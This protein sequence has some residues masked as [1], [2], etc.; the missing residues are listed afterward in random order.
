MLFLRLQKGL[1]FNFIIP[2]L[3]FHYNIIKLTIMQIIVDIILF[4]LVLGI[5]G[6]QWDTWQFWLLLVLLIIIATVNA[7][8]GYKSID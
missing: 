2:L 3:T 6:L 5:S 4:A 7:V 8:G 1:Y